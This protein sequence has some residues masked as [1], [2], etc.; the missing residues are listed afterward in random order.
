MPNNTDTVRFNNVPLEYRPATY[1]TVIPFYSSSLPYNQ[2]G[3]LW[4][5]SDDGATVLYKPSTTV[6]GYISGQYVKG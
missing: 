3:S 2:I 6:S 4:I 1:Y 5:R